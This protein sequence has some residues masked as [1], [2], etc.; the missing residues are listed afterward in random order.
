[1]KEK[2]VSSTYTE[3]S[4]F[5]IREENDPIKSRKRFKRCFAKGDVQMTNEHKRRF[6]LLL[7]EKKAK[8]E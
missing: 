5:S 3:L 4:K 2:I 8:T 7:R 6:S 1:M